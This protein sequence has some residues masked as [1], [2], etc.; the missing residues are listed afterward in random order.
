[1]QDNKR[2]NRHKAGEG[3]GTKTATPVRT[4]EQE[5]AMHDGLRILARIIARA[6][7]RRQS[8]EY[9][10]IPEAADGERLSERAHDPPPEPEGGG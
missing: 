4:E 2:Q 5:Q 3:T 10:P 8:I 6:H 7:L 9:G 1:M